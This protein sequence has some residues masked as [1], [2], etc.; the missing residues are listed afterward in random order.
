MHTSMPRACNNFPLFSVLHLSINLKWLCTVYMDWCLIA[1]SS[2]LY[3]VQIYTIPTNQYS[4]TCD[5]GNHSWLFHFHTLVWLWS[6]CIIHFK[7]NTWLHIYNLWPKQ[8][9][10]WLHFNLLLYIMWF[11]VKFFFKNSS[12]LNFILIWNFS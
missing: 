10:I 1:S 2:V 3:L 5:L 7:L 11:R 12:Y 6:H 8:M 4:Y 9:L